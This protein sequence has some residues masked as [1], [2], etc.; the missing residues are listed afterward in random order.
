MQQVDYYY[1]Y[2]YYSDMI[3]HPKK[4]KKMKMNVLKIKHPIEW[5]LP[6]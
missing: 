1:Y 3:L 5:A 6:F 4:L 2:Y